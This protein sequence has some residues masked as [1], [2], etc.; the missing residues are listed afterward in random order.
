MAKD[1]IPDW[2]RLAAKIQADVIAED[3]SDPGSPISA[4]DAK[5][6]VLHTRHDMIMLISLLTTLNQ[7]ADA[8]NRRLR[9][10]MWL[11][12]GLIVVAGSVR[13]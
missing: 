8:A 7:S 12:V 3:A 2:L 9:I 4:H 13:V 11:L 1:P 6:A 10:M 5:R